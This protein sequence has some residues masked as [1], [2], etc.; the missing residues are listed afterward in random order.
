MYKFVINGWKWKL[1]L[2][3]SLPLNECIIKGVDLFLATIQCLVSVSN[4]VS[5]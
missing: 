5:D 4:H 3:E 1:N 2:Y